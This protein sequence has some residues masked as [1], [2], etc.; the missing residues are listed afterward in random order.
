VLVSV[1]PILPDPDAAIPVTLA[2]LSLVQLNTVPAT[3]P[4]STI[5]VIGT[6]EHFVCED[7]VATA[8]GVGLTITVAVVPVPG[9]LLAV[10]VIVNVTVT[11]ALVVL[12]SVPDILPEPLAAIPVTATVLSLVQ[13]Y[14]VPLTLPESTIVVIAVPEQLVCEDGVATA[15]GVGFTSTVAVIGVP[16]QVTPAL[17]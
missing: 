12:V 1:P 17:V 16:L 11:G 14:V 5:V 13:L 2:T 7:G 8:L 4:V 6:P 10:V 9:Q 15:F 3:L